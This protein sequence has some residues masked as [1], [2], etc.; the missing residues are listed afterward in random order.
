MSDRWDQ[1]NSV[2]LN[3]VGGEPSARSALLV[4]VCPSHPAK[5]DHRVGLTRKIKIYKHFVSAR[6]TSPTRTFSPSLFTDLVVFP[7][8]IS[9]MVNHSSRATFPSD[10][11]SL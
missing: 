5:F 1:I 10:I 4:A 9:E 7:E 3:V 6:T 2:F 11:L 8:Q